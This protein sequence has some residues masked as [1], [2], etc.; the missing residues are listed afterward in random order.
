MNSEMDRIVS[1]VA[2]PAT[3]ILNIAASLPPIGVVLSTIVSAL[4]I[5]HYSIAIFKALKGKKEGKDDK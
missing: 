1:A 2:W 5:V 4:A 3:L